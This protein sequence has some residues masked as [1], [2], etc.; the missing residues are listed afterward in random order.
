MGAL[1]RADTP[2]LLEMAL[3]LDFEE[4]RPRLL[5]KHKHPE[6]LARYPAGVL[7]DDLDGLVEEAARSANLLVL[8]WIWL[9][10]GATV[11]CRAEWF[12]VMVPMLAAEA[13]HVSVLEWFEAH[14][15]V[16]DSGNAHSQYVHTVAKH[17]ARAGRV[18]V[19]AWLAAAHVVDD[20]VLVLTEA[21]RHGKINVLE[22]WWWAQ[23]WGPRSDPDAVRTAWMAVLRGAADSGHVSVMRWAALY[24]D[25][26]DAVTV[27]AGPADNDGGMALVQLADLALNHTELATVEWLWHVHGSLAD[28]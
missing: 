3:A 7:A 2:Y 23:S 26:G 1:P 13:G 28:E 6:L 20:K 25:L 22:W 12:R 17:A 21:A 14:S 18:D 4:L 8:H 11:G 10:Y 16:T 9:S 27:A 15:P 24:F 19:L 5:V